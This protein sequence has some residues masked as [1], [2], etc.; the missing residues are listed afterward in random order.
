[1]IILPPQTRLRHIE[2]RLASF[3]FV[4]RAWREMIVAV[5]QAKI[6]DGVPD[7]VLQN[8]ERDSLLPAEEVALRMSNPRFL[9]LCEELHDER[10]PARI[11]RSIGVADMV[12]ESLD[13]SQP[14]Q[15]PIYASCQMYRD[16]PVALYSR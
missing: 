4:P 12:R 6:S 3:A 11:L 2:E 15:W 13:E 7:E 10:N 14:W 16:N 5:W 8:Y 1:M 9:A